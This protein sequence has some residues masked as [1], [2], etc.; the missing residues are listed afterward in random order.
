MWEHLRME[1]KD[2]PEARIRELERGISDQAGASELGIGPNGTSELP[3][4]LPPGSYGTPYPPP[5][6]YG[7]PPPGSFGTPYPPGPGS[8]GGAS[9]GGAPFAPVRSRSG[10]RIGW[11]LFAIFA[12]VGI[13]VI[14]SVVAVF[15]NVS[16]SISSIESSFPTFSDN[17]TPANVPSTPGSSS[18]PI[19]AGHSVNVAGSGKHETLVCDGGSVSISGMTNT[20]DITGHCAKVTV[21]GVQNKVV[22]ES[23]DDIEASGMKNAVTYHS[24]SP[25]VN[26]S[27]LD[28]S[29]DEG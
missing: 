5:P 28:N 20:V 25:Q 27:G 9:F 3:P 22:V 21:S 23:A 6:S 2:D 15:Y 8:F 14:G 19:T 12:F 13:S 24:G 4:P 16:N 18:I 1:S 26:K 29:V 10:F 17:R 11:L 7:A